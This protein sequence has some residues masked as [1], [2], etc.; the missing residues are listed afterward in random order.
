MFGLQPSGSGMAPYVACPFFRVPPHLATTPALEFTALSLYLPCLTCRPADPLTSPPWL[1]WALRSSTAN[2]SAL[3]H[4][5]PELH[6]RFY[7]MAVCPLRQPLP[8]HL[9]TLFVDALPAFG[10]TFSTFMH[11]HPSRPY[12]KVMPM[13]A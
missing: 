13:D 8:F 11:P 7:R 5:R 4:H 2:A 3:V 9:F 1:T 12:E 6:L 10:N